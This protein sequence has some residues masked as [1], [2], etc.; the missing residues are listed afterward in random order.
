MNSV[1]TLFRSWGLKWR[2]GKGLP[3]LRS[4]YAGKP[5][6]PPEMGMKICRDTR[7]FALLRR[8]LNQGL[9]SLWLAPEWFSPFPLVEGWYKDE[10]CA[11][12]FS[13]LGA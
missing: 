10:W 3:A 11:D 2:R 12:A 6:P 5:F 8:A 7:H 13:V 4:G 9:R 1:R